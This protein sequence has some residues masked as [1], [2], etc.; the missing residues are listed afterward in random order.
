MTSHE[1]VA[2]GMEIDGSQPLNVYFLDNGCK[3]MLVD[4]D[5]TSEMVCEELAK[6]I[7]FNTEECE[8]IG[9]YFCLYESV[10]GQLANRPIMAQENILQVQ[11]NCAKFH[12]QLSRINNFNAHGCCSLSRTDSFDLLDNVH[13]LDDI[14]ENYVSAVE[15]RSF[16]C[17]NEELRSVGVWS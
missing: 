14:T 10:D 16:H 3:M 1:A 9:K 13:A 7:G 15:P 5:T 11:A 8:Q 2:E 6:K 17:A 12:G 4:R